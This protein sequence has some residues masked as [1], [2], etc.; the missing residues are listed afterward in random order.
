MVSPSGLEVEGRRA[1]ELIAERC[2]EPL[3]IHTR[4]FRVQRHVKRCDEP[5]AIHTRYQRNGSSMAYTW[6]SAFGVIPSAN[7]GANIGRYKGDVKTKQIEETYCIRLSTGPAGNNGSKPPD[8]LSLA[9]ENK[10]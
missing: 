8:E 2:D 4:E 1:T 10:H 5:L 7:R 3:A 9:R 6:M